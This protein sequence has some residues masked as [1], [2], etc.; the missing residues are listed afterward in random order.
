MDDIVCNNKK[1]IGIVTI[2]FGFNYGSVL[3]SYALASY[4]NSEFQWG[5]AKVIDYIPNR[6]ALKNRIFQKRGRLLIKMIY[7]FAVIPF[8][9]ITQIKFERFIRKHIPVTDRVHSLQEVDVVSREMDLLIT[10]SDQVWNTDYNGGIDPVY[11]LFFGRKDAYRLAY[12]ASCGKTYSTEEWRQME[13]LLSKIDRITLREND[14]VEFFHKKGFVNAEQLLDPTFLVP[15]DEWMKLA[16]PPKIK[17]YVLVYALDK[18]VD[19]LLMVAHRIA[20]TSGLKVAVI[21][22]CH[23]WNRYDADYVFRNKTPAEFLGLLSNA[24]AVVT[25]SFHGI[26]FSIILEKQF[27]VLKREKY[28]SRLDS[29]LQLFD[30]KDRYVDVDSSAFDIKKRIDYHKVNAVKN[31]YIRKSQKILQE[32]LADCDAKQDSCLGD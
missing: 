4:L 27:Y 19:E 25:N 16:K 23:V 7:P 9:V 12:A 8:Q 30:L 14:A 1:K 29:V 21:N 11:Y 18:K 26:A 24:S 22:Y 32:A 15:K 6:Y 5:C 28:N 10:G 17:D 3:Q 2:H 31:E 20:S 13:A